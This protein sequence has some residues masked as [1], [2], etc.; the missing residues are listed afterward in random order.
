MEPEGLPL[1]NGPSRSQS[2][3]ESIDQYK[4]IDLHS[5]GDDRQAQIVVNRRSLELFFVFVWCCFWVQSLDALGN[6]GFILGPKLGLINTDDL[7]LYF[8]L[9]MALSL[10][11]VVLGS[12]VAGILKA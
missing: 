5:L 1:F 8:A 9:L 6:M 10:V 11:S 2:S 7:E 3:T 4:T 12:I